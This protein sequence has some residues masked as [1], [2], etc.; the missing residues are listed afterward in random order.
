MVVLSGGGSSITNCYV[1]A[2]TK[3]LLRENDLTN[4]HYHKFSAHMLLSYP[5]DAGLPLNVEASCVCNRKPQ[6]VAA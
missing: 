4:L 2:N 1:N 3:S 6:A 5:H